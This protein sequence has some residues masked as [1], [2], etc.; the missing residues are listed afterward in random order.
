MMIVKESSVNYAPVSNLAMVLPS[1][2]RARLEPL[3]KPFGDCAWY[4]DIDGAVAAASD[5]DLIWLTFH[6][7]DNHDLDRVLA[8]GTRLRWV[9]TTM[10]GVDFLD[11]KALARRGVML[12]NG[13]GI[14]AE[15]IAEHVIMCMLAANRGLS[16]LVLAQSRQAWI[17]PNSEPRELAGCQALVIGYGHLGRAIAAKARALGVEVVGV[18]R[19]QSSE[20]GVVAGDEWR[21]SLATA[22]FVV[23]CVPLT[24][25]TRHLIAATELAAMKPGAWLINVGRGG[26]VDEDA[27]VESL[28]AGA[29]GGAAIDVVE[30]EPL[31]PDHPLW[32]APRLLITPHVSWVSN[33]TDERAV[34]L[35]TRR[36]RQFVDDPAT[37]PVVDAALGY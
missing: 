30:H 25:Q 2:V 16:E 20:P 37:M 35:F 21:G 1:R 28:H 15:P 10:T 12:T 34:E 29:I 3:V 22:D 9:H 6:A 14:P 11:L 26:L 27:L 24:D 23:L 7:H 19:T 13:A 8:A 18:R 31:P 17:K 36:L 33:R 5:A 32:S 4:D